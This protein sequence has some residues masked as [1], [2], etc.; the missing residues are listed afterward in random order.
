[1]KDDPN[2]VRFHN[3]FGNYDALIAV[4]KFLEPKAFL[5]R[6]S[7]MQSWVIKMPKLKYQ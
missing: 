1:M 5:A 3:G 4:F 7:Q 6:H 2:A